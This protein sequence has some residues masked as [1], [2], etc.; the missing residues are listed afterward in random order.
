MR[1]GQK[2]DLLNPIFQEMMDSK[3]HRS[4][5]RLKKSERE[6]DEG[7]SG[8]ENELKVLHESV[9]ELAK[10][11]VKTF[12]IV[13]QRLDKQNPWL[14]VNGKFFLF[15]DLREILRESWLKDELLDFFPFCS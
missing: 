1:H 2:V 8:S 12:E 10:D 5:K 6:P 14:N 11:K 13:L 9:G 3:L 7:F 4:S 15:G